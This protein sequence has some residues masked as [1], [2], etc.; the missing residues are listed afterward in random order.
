M[1]LFPTIELQ[2]GKCV[3]LNSGRLGEPSIWHV[4]VLEKAQEFAD[5]GAGWIQVTD[6]DAIVGS[7]TSRALVESV[8]RQTPASVQV[9]GGIRTL[10]QIARWIDF[11]AGRVVIG[12]A[13]TLDPAFVQQAALHYPDQIVLAV[14]VWEGKVMN[15]GWTEKTAFDPVDFGKRFDDDP[16]AAILFTDIDQEVRRTEA[17]LARV[18]AFARALRNPVIARGHVSELDDISKLKYVYNV[19][20]AVIGRALFE[21]TIDLGEALDVAQPEPE[22]VAAF[23]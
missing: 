11:G 14:D 13:A 3:S 7:D 6:F 15:H 18:T 1:Q 8:I 9:G 20:G 23:Q 2:D 21:K 10:D 12:T 17:G 19:D 5:A 4:D 22:P 16:L